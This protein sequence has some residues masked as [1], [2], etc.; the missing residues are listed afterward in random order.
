VFAAG[1]SCDGTGTPAVVMTYWNL[2]EQYGPARFA[3][4]LANAGGAGAITP[5]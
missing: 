5:T 3:R 4:D 2:V 1:R